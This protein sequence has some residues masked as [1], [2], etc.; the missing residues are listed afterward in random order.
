MAYKLKLPDTARIHPVFHVSLL[1][2]S[3]GDYRVEQHLPVSLEGDSLHSPEPV[4]VLATRAVTKGG[5]TVKHLLI[6]WKD[7]AVEDATWEEEFNIKSQFP[8][9]RLEDKFV[10]HEGAVMVP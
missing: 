8:D 2:K 7:K 1:K 9:F 6:Q 3:V 4:A 10:L 5:E